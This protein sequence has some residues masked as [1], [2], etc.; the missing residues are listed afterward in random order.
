MGAE[1][2]TVS[3]DLD[4][5]EIGPELLETEMKHLNPSGLIRASSTSPQKKELRVRFSSD[6][7]AA[8][9]SFKQKANPNH[10]RHRTEIFKDA[11]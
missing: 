11:G 10:E 6:A 9:V 7:V 1:V 2:E 3:D 4:H 8:E 5:S